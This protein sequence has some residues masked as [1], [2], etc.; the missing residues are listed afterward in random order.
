MIGT[1][2]CRTHCGVNPD[3]AQ[4]KGQAMHA[5][6]A[7]SGEVELAPADAVLGMLRMSWVR[8]HF[9][10]SLLEEQVL[11]A[12]EDLDGADTDAD[13]DADGSGDRTARTRGAGAVGPG[14][15]LIGH[16]FSAVRDVGIFAT[17]EKVRGLVEL[18]AAE[19]DRVVKYAKVA[20]D[21]GI[22]DREIRLAEQQGALLASAVKKILAG[23]NLSV[24]QQELVPQLVP[25]VLR[26]VAA[27][28]AA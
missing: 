2:A 26:A 27:G 19:R 15:G 3:L 14:A 25:T 12:Q 18:E 10:A 1:D 22:A 28:D 24:E 17:G 21:M 9:Y 6:S 11:E 7:V 13:A 20:H 23:L 16:V 4:A 5:W 8:A